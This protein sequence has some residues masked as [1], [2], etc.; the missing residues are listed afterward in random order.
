MFRL[1]IGV[2]PGREGST[3]TSKT[4]IWEE[5]RDMRHL[6]HGEPPRII[7]YLFVHYENSLVES[8]MEV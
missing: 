4:K 6:P 7:I 1:G 2:I 8:L 5:H 3:W